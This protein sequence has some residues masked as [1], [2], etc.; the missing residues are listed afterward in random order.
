[1]EYAINTRNYIKRIFLIYFCYFESYN[2]YDK[3]YYDK[4]FPLMK[5]KI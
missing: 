1:M 2:L 5:F 3:S 4:I